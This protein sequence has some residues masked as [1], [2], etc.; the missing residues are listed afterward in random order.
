LSLRQ[1]IRFFK[2]ATRTL[3]SSRYLL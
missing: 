2:P 1:S 3:C